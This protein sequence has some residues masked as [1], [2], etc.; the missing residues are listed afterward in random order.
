M[1]ERLQKVLASAGVGSRRVIE[2]W[3]SAGRIT[4][5]GNVAT[6]GTKVTGRERILVDGRPVPALRKSRPG[7][8]VLLYHKPAGEVCS[9]SD[10]EGRPTVFDRLPPLEGSRWISVGRLDIATSGL[11][12]LT[13]DGGLANTLM[14]PRYGARKVYRIEVHPPLER[15]QAMKLSKGVML[16]DGMAQALDVVE[17][18]PAIYEVTLS[19]GRKR[20]LRRMI[21][22]LGSHVLSLTRIEQAGVKLG[23]LRPGRWRELN[24][25]EMKLLRAKAES[26]S[27]T[28]DYED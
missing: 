14:H 23:N 1:T 15:P 21:A 2:Q 7:P 28:Q 27:Q 6:L 18:S 5:N 9:R 17:I 19:E 11:L 25:A 3:I 22:A 10:P 16:S 20:Q 8:R 4:V 26:T 12:L 13:T 24:G